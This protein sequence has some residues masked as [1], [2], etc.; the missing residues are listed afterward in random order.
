MKEPS[1]FEI[2]FEKSPG[3][4]VIF[5]PPL[6]NLQ[7]ESKKAKLTHESDKHSLTQIDFIVLVLYMWM[8]I[9]I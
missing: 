2:V 8:M 9:T 7:I 1:T 4:G 5:D 3:G 6:L